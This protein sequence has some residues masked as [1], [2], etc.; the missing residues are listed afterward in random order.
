MSNQF[1]FRRMLASKFFV[2]GFS[3]LLVIVFIAV[4]APVIV[5]YD[6][7]QN[8]LA[9]RLRAPEFFSKGWGG[10]ILGTD[11]MGRDVFTRL[12]I[13]ARYSLFIALTVVVLAVILG[14]F[15]GVLSGYFGGLVDTII[16]RTCDA[17]LA[18]PNMVLAIAVMAVLGSNT[19][20]LIA[21][22]VITGWVQYCKL[23]RNNVMVVKNMEFV[24]ASQALGASKM[25]IMFKQILPNVTTQLLIVLSQ[26][27]G[28]VILLEA[29]LS[30]LNL[31]IQPPI[32]S[33]G[34]MIANG[35]DYLVTC[36]WLVFSPGIALM[37]TV[38][39]FNFLG[40][41]VRDVLDPK[42]T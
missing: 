36:P 25:H 20:N 15:L 29:A 4:I 24:H 13:G 10:H 27:L 32:P 42:Q 31:G 1:L 40:D 35:R 21:V 6:P 17:F 14:T 5:V 7:I 8:S 16:M 18:V 12:I 2:V 9:E 30:F 34:N 37:L 28:F 41:G 11:Q 26:Q 38:L 3:V 19:F 22:L 23:S 39:A 33:W